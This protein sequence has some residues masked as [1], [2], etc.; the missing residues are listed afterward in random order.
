M[1]YPY[2][3]GCNL[4]EKA[5]ALDLA[6]RKS[7]EKL[8]FNLVELEEWTCC[9]ATF[10]LAEDNN[11]ALLSPT[12]VLA[13][14]RKAGEDLVTLCAVCHNVLK[15]TNHVMTNNAERR[16]TVTEFIE[17][18]YDG[19]LKVLHYLE[20]LRDRIGFSELASKVEVPLKGLKIAS[21]YGCLLLRPAK[22]MAFDDPD[23]PTILEDLFT[24]LG[25]EPVDFPMK[26]ECCGAFQVLNSDVTATRC[27]R[28][29]L[30]SAKARGA[31][32]VVTACPL[33]QFNIEDRQ[34]AMKKDSLDFQTLPVLYFTELLAL[35]L[36]LGQDMIAAESHYVDPM[37][38]LISRGLASG[39]TAG[40]Q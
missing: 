29:I 28:E 15:R 27:S 34:N 16:K 4:F 11:M 19:S 39:R 5:K 30:D 21:Y 35:A 36:G 6:A 14:G 33:C 22:E 10:P 31:D 3:P 24:A 17:E 12:R 8:G 7:S 26:T 23:R 25:A 38:L 1:N 20:V 18:P 13:N 32:V 9:G 2:F 40:G 37:P